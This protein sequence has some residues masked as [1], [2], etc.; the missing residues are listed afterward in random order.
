MQE[1]VDPY[2]LKLD[3]EWNKDIMR[4]QGRH[5][6]YYHD[7]VLERM[8]QAAREAGTDKAR[9]LELYEKYV[10]QPTREAPEMLRRFW[11]EEQ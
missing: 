1:V 8:R 10:K 4:H 6:N 7:F 3:E 11:W 9:F 2:G 5:T